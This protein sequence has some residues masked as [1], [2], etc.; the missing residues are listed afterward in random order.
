MAK[1]VD[2][3]NTAA[4]VQAEANRIANLLASSSDAHTTAKRAVLS[5][6]LLDTPGWLFCRGVPRDIR[7][8]SLG[9]GVYKIWT[10]AQ[11]SGRD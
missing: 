2:R 3:E 9:A 4:A 1:V 10:E 5:R 7:S 6:L 11:A 8:R